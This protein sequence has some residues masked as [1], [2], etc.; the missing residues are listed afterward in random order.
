VVY[1]GRKVA[2]VRLS[3]LVGL[4]V[5]LCAEFDDEAKLLGMPSLIPSMPSCEDVR[6]R[7]PSFLG[8]G[9]LESGPASPC[10]ISLLDRFDSD[11]RGDI[12]LLV[13]LLLLLLVLL[14]VSDNSMG[15]CG[16]EFIVPGGIGLG[17]RSTMLSRFC[18]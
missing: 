12:V 3:D 5:L 10:K 16:G 9:K 1:G 4:E 14:G 2:D 7:G 11:R 18:S 6:V 17:P 15:D 13:V 8:K